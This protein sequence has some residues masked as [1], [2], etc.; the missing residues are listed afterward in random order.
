VPEP[1][2]IARYNT[3]PVVR[4]DP[5]LSGAKRESLEHL[6]GLGYFEGERD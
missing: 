3:R 2:L 6:R 5:S 4:V 1:P